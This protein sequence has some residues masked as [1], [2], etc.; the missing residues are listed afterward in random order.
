[1]CLKGEGHGFKC[2]YYPV[3]TRTKEEWKS[4]PG[5]IQIAELDTHLSIPLEEDTRMLFEPKLESAKPIKES[6]VAQSR[7]I[8]DIPR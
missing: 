6:I 5:S 1:M 4:V 8:D 3:A 7:N 2:G